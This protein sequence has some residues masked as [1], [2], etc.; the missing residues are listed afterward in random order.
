VVAPEWSKSC[1]AHRA[2]HRLSLATAS[3][4]PSLIV[5][6]NSH[7]R[8]TDLSDSQQFSS[9]LKRD[10]IFGLVCETVCAYDF[11][12]LVYAVWV[13]LQEKHPESPPD[14]I[15]GNGASLDEEDFMPPLTKLKTLSD[16]STKSVN[17][18]SYLVYELKDLFNV[19]QRPQNHIF[20]PEAYLIV[21]DS[22]DV[23]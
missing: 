12:F 19:R 3:D 20:P 16:W 15:F 9:S 10:S 1:P 18:L 2:S 22:F 8:K 13:L 7:V 5:E 21:L 17:S 6:K 11:E 4:S 14:F 23:V